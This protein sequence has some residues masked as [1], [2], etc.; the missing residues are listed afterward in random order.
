VLAGFYPGRLSFDFAPAFIKEARFR[1]AS[2]FT[3]LD[4]LAVGQLAGAGALSLDGLITHRSE[5]QGAETAYRTAFSDAGCLKMVLD[6][7]AN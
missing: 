2:E 3:P 7:R 5:P 4:L 1:I 6:W